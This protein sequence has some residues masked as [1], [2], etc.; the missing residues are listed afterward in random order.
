MKAL[1]LA[2][3]AL[4]FGC[5]NYSNEDLEFMNAVPQTADLSVE[6]P[7]VSAIRPALQDDALK[8]TLEVTTKMNAGATSLLALVDKLRTIYPTSRDANT[9]LWGPWPADGNPGWQLEFAM[10]RTLLADGLTPHFDYE[11]V[12]IPP[13]GVVIGGG[14]KSSSQ[15]LGGAFDSTGLARAGTGRMWLTPK[16]ARDA[17]AVLKDLEKLDALTITYDNRAWPRSLDMTIMNEPPAIPTD[18]AQSAMYS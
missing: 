18:E 3:L 8:M 6:S 17:G 2:L 11:L 12:M 16:E 5:G 14:T 13:A 9:R 1:G 7:R 15:V 4:A 10:T